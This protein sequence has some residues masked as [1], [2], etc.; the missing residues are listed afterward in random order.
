MLYLNNLKSKANSLN[1]YIT[2]TQRTRICCSSAIFNMCYGTPA[3]TKSLPTKLFSATFIQPDVLKVSENDFRGLHLHNLESLRRY[4]FTL[5]LHNLT[6]TTLIQ[7]N[8]RVLHLYNL[9]SLPTIRF[10]TVRWHNLTF[11]TFEQLDFRVLHLHNLK[12]LSLW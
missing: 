12:S 3:Q 4:N 2:L 10:C 11:A 8:F 6:F 7:F 5:H 1:L 9:K